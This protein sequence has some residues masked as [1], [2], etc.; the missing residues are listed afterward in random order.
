[1]KIRALSL[2]VLMAAVLQSDAGGVMSKS[3]V[4]MNHAVGSFQVTTQLT[5]HAP[6]PSL[7]SYALN[8]QYHGDIEAT[9]KGEMLAVGSPV[10]GNGGYVALERVTG[11][12]SGKVGSFAIMQFGTM[13]NGSLPQMTVAIAPGSGTGDLSGIQ[14]S[15]TIV[16]ADGKHTYDLQYTLVQQ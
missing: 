16:I 1:M 15:M 5:D 9:A 8:K 14:G 3:E 10:T 2:S 7:T 4:N 13:Q 12:V 6:D 11:K